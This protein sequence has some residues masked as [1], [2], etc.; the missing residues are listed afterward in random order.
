MS[1]SNDLSPRMMLK[2]DLKK[3][4][5]VQFELIMIDTKQLLLNSESYYYFCIKNDF[6]VHFTIF[7][8]SVCK[9]NN[10]LNI[11]SNFIRDKDQVCE[12]EF[13]DNDERYVFIKGIKDMLMEWT[14]SSDWDNTNEMNKI[15]YNNEIWILF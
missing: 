9:N 14:N 15:S 11:P 13:K 5:K 1:R 4:N 7:D 2:V 12:L 10:M 3:R 8:F 6:M